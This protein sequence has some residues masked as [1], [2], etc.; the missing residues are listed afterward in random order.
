[1]PV[2]LETVKL[3]RRFQPELKF[4]LAEAP[5]VP[6]RL[7]D[8][9]LQGSTGIVR[10]FGVSH[11]ILA[12]ANASIVKSGS[13]TVEA[14]YFGNPFVVFYRIAPLSYAIGKRVV[15]VPFIAMP[16]L[17]AGE[18]VVPE[19]IQS[20][21]TAENLVGAL[22]PLLTVPQEIEACRARLRKVRESLGQPGAGKKVADI[23]VDLLTV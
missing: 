11:A 6:S 21:A 19:L 20:E 18:R 13:T 14:A 8:R 15:K 3:L 4:I 5:G 16:N 1:L 10:A 7:Y 12:H 23:A 22:M 17:L 2:L 9:L